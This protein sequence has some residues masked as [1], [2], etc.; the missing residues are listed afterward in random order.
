MSKQVPQQQ[1]Q[2]TEQQ[3]PLKSKCPKY[4]KHASSQ[5]RW[6]AYSRIVSKNFLGV[7]H[8]QLLLFKL[9]QDPSWRC[10]LASTW[11]K[12]LLLKL[13]FR[14][15]QEMQRKQLLPSKCLHFWQLGRTNWLGSLLRGKLKHWDQYF[16]ALSWDG[17]HYTYL[18]ILTDWLRS[19]FSLSWGGRLWQKKIH[20]FGQDILCLAEGPDLRDPLQMSVP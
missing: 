2:P 6:L 17:R 3:Q 19:V 8:V 4:S 13:S 20:M 9:N 14:I 12:I 7:V 10:I 18:G 5:M 1:T 15:A 11:N 16:F